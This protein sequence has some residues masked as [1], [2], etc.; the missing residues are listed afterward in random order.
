MLKKHECLALSSAVHLSSYDVV[1]YTH[2]DM[3]TVN[4]DTFFSFQELKREE[5]A[6]DTELPSLAAFYKFSPLMY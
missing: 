3:A 5:H 4:V 2:V 6:N 1:T